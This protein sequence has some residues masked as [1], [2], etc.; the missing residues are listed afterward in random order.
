MRVAIV[1]ATGAVGQEFLELLSKRKFPLTTLTL[2]ASER[3]AG[4]QVSF[5][6]QELSVQ[7]LPEDGDLHADVVFSSAGGSISK[8]RAWDWARHGATVID[9][10]SA[11]R[12]DERVP[13]VVPEINPEDALAHDGVIANPNCSTIIALMALAPL[14]RAFGLTRATI[15]TYQAVSG[16]GAAGIDELTLQTKAALAGETVAPKKFQHTIA[17]NLFSH[18]SDV[19]EDGYNVEERKL[20]QESRKILHAPRLA[21]QRD[22]RAGARVPRSLRSDSRRVRTTGECGGGSR[23]LA[24]RRRFATQRR[25][26]GQHFSHASKRQRARRLFCGPHPRGCQ[27]A[28]RYRPVRRGRPS[29]QRGGAERRAN[30]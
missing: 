20:L 21:Y 11:W 3:S 22:L 4:K 25:P 7:A 19:G 6:A 29:A 18:D 14:H 2:Y 8:A 16:A 12:M 26:R 24:R 13:L 9:N 28:R 10:T 15:A 5:G 1:G 27:P 30:R 17:F 23:G